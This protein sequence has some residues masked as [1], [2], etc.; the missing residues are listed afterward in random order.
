MS[1][2]DPEDKYDLLDE[3]WHTPRSAQAMGKIFH[4]CG[5]VLLEQLQP[6]DPRYV[7]ATRY[8][9][10]MWQMVDRYEQLDLTVSPITLASSVYV[11]FD[12]EYGSPDDPM[13]GHSA[14]EAQQMTDA[15]LMVDNLL[16]ERLA[17]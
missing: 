11:E 3:R 2:A 9:G 13:P 1:Q 14:A 7:H 15:V 16:L 10:A 5:A 17:V 6:E 8:L 12:A 4:A